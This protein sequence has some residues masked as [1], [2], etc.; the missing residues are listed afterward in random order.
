MEKIEQI[1]VPVDGSEGARHALEMGLQLAN[2]CDIPLKLAYVV[3]L[4]A[5]S[6]MAL[7]HLEKNDVEQTSQRLAHD[8]LATARE[9]VSDD[10]GIVAEEVVLVGDAATEIINFLD[11]HP[12]TLV[13][14]GRRGLSP[15]KHLVLGSVSDKVMRYGGTAVMVVG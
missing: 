1:L 2:R 13:V 4:T 8:V 6:A 14:M 3:P 12:G 10:S 11:N 15:I 7:A 5:E 9:A